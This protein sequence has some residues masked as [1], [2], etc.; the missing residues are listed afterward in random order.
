M[1]RR[2]PIKKT[3]SGEGITLDRAVALIAAH[4]GEVDE[5]KI[6][7][8]SYVF[9]EDVLSEFGHKLHYDAVVNYAGNSFME[10]SWDLIAGRHRGTLPPR[11]AAQGQDLDG[12]GHGGSRAGV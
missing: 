12:A 8:M 2:K 5:D 10:K 7:S 11:T 4:L 6:N 3:D 9:F 1:T